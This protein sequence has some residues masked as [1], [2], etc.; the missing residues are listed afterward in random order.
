V[1]LIE[2]RLKRVMEQLN[3]DEEAARKEISRFDDS[4]REFVKRY[5]Q[6]DITDPLNY[7]VV[8]NTRGLSAEGAAAI[9][10][11]AVRKRGD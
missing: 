3:R 7:D 8:I 4:S 9:I 10:A 6:A 11:D 5:F 1:A 2:V